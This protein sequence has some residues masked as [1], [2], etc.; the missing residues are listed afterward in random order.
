MLNGLDPLVLGNTAGLF[1]AVGVIVQGS[2]TA[3]ISIVKKTT[4]QLMPLVG[5]EA[6]VLRLKEY[7]E[8]ALLLFLV[9]SV[10]LDSVKFEVPAERLRARVGY[11]EFVRR[12]A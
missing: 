10:A 8:V 2:T 6:S 5:E 7:V 9:E 3:G 11:G 4:K 12:T 1:V